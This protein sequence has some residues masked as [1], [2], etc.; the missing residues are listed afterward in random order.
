MILN[1]LVFPTFWTFCL[2]SPFAVCVFRLWSSYFLLFMSFLAVLILLIS[3]DL[4]LSLY[5]YINLL[6][7]VIFFLFLLDL[8][9]IITHLRGFHEIEFYWKAVSWKF[10][11]SFIIY[12]NS[13]GLGLLFDLFLFFILNILVLLCFFPITL[14]FFQIKMLYHLVFFY[15]L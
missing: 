11:F 10:N 7:I 13:F 1:L 14:L 8:V 3:S 15:L 6:L 12:G 2:W 9:E 5:F 4:W